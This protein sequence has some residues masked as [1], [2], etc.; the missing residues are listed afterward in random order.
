[1]QNPLRTTTNIQRQPAGKAAGKAGPE[2]KGL[3]REAEDA[4]PGPT[5]RRAQAT[6][7][8]AGPSTTVP[9]QVVTKKRWTLDDFDVG[10]PLGKGKF[11]NV[12][13]AREK[14]SKF[15]VALKVRLHSLL[16]KPEDLVPWLASRPVDGRKEHA[17]HSVT[18][19]P[20]HTHARCSSR[21]SC[22]KRTLNTSC[23]ERWR[24]SRTC[25]TQTS[26]ACTATS[27]TRSDA[28]F[29]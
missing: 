23:G 14:K 4:N 19:R 24:F 2:K 1:M 11:G 7:E 3:K 12:Y 5:Q 27:T 25:D 28:T 29:A 26:F 15:I 6:Q 8:A 22:S 16:H 20:E 10:K 13:L 18:N 17:R 9:A 21:A